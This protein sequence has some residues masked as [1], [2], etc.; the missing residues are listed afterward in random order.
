MNL[1]M[2]VSFSKYVWRL[3]SVSLRRLNPAPIECL[4][5]EL[6]VDIERSP[7]AFDLGFWGECAQNLACEISTVSSLGQ[8][9]LEPLVYDI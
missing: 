1:V 6:R 9:V 2:T 8:L 5:L 3:V 7:V 4:R